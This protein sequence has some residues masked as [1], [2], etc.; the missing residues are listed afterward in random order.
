MDQANKDYDKLH[1]ISRHTRTLQGIAHLLDWDQETYMPSDAGGIRAEQLK[2]LA[3]VIHKEKTGRKFSNAL[4]KLIDLNTGKV[5]AQGLEKSQEAALHEWL[6]DYRHATALPTKF[7]EEFTQLTAQAIN[8]WRLSKQEDTF[9][10]FAP[11][12][13]KIVTM[14]RRKADLLGYQDNPYDALLDEYEPKATTK[15]IDTLFIQLRTSL[16][17]LLKK[18]KSRPQVE[19]R[20]LFDHFDHEKQNAFSQVLLKAIGYD[21]NKGRLDTSSHPFS[22][23]FHPTDSRITTRIHAN[24]IMDNISSVLHE[25]GH[26][27]YEMGL[28]IHQYGSPLGEACSLGIHESQSRWWE[29]RIGLSKPF[30]SH[31]LPQLKSVFHGK[32]D[33]ITLDQFYKG[34]NTVKPS[35][36]RVEADEV[37]YSLHVILRFELERDLINGKLS[38]RDIPEAWNSKMKEY[39]GIIPTTNREGCLQ[40]IHWAMGG[41]GYFPTYTLGN[42]YAA[43]LFKTFSHQ[44]AN[45]EEHVA[46]GEL[47]FIREWLQDKIYQHG[48]RY[49]SEALL[50]QA[51]GRDVTSQDYLDYLNQKYHDIYG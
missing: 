48:R 1:A 45:W 41:F 34:I 31:F 15:G 40:D 42:I 35:L 2:V 50:K 44:H 5:I 33:H 22:A 36:I 10:R 17:T 51:T 46:K 25:G 29:T 39:L 37:T 24:A 13:E 32:F 9:Y 4:K 43:H 38:V 12:L 26:S 49:H 3:G 21:L 47:F 7:V 28:P 16:V 6:R 8:V 27:L 14:C 23:S 20:F 11:F 19:S 18:I 30:W